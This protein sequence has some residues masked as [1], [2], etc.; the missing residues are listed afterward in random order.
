MSLYEV[1]GAAVF[2]VVAIGIG[3]LLCIWMIPKTTEVMVNASA[4]LTARYL[5]RRHRT[6]VINCSTNNPEA[7]SMLVA[8]GLGRIGGIANPL[9]SN[10]AN[11]YLIFLL[12]PLYVIIKLGVLGR[13]GEALAFIRLFRR[14]W[15]LV[16]WHIGLAA[17]M[18]GFAVVAYA[19]LLGQP[20]GD[21]DTTPE[22]G[23]MPSVT[24]LA[25]L[26]VLAIGAVGVLIFVRLDRWLQL[27][28]P[29]LYDDIN[30]EGHSAS[31]MRFFLGSAGLVAAC[32]VMNSLFLA[33]SQLFADSLSLWIG[34]AV[35]AGLHYFV[36]ALITSLP[37]LTV[38]ARNYARINQPDLNTAMAS[39]SVSNMTNLA[40]ATI[41]AGVSAIILLLGA[42]L[43]V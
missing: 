34:A 11:I 32:Y 36:G 4:G 38:A 24:L 18:W 20:T 19:I 8:M 6:L 2:S 26:A 3:L 13:S 29:H 30:E 42:R 22:P 1:T 7:V 9:G 43:L 12:A 17:L 10:L 35:F 41:G 37:E 31:W 16:A 27:R 39:A 33:F 14:N 25:M 21:F 40:I 5:G 28:K 15:K 23:S